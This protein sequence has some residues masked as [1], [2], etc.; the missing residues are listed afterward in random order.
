MVNDRW[1]SIDEAMVKQERFSGLNAKWGQM[2]I[3]RV[4]PLSIKY[5]PAT[6]QMQAYGPPPRLR[7]NAPCQS[8]FQYDMVGVIALL[9]T[10]FGHH[11]ADLGTSPSQR[12][13]RDNI[14]YGLA[15][16]RLSTM[17]ACRTP[18]LR[19]CAHAYDGTHTHV[20]CMMG[21]KEA[22]RTGQLATLT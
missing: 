7:T 2:Q 5:R 16:P 12:Q 22:N 8:A 20:S 3:R 4:I 19:A 21:H 18:W 15:A 10:G 9:L 11:T 13:P 17:R 1:S 6:C 14:A